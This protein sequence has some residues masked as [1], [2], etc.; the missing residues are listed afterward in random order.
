MTTKSE[1]IRAVELRLR[2]WARHRAAVHTQYEAMMALTGADSESALWRPVFAL[3]E[4]Y[5]EAVRESVG[6]G[7]HWL[8]W[9][10]QECGMGKRPK[11][12]KS[13][14]GRRIRVGT[15]RELARVICDQAEA[16]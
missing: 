2:E 1:R 16:L 10:E 3:W 5:T 7:E 15:L 14:S 13:L 9:Y 11:E 6:D 4:A 8:Q 12:V